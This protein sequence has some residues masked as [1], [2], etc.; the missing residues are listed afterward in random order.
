MPTIGEKFTFTL[1]D[2][3]TFT[4]IRHREGFF[5]IYKDGKKVWTLSARDAAILIS[6][7]GG[8]E[9]E[10][11]PVEIARNSVNGA[12]QEEGQKRGIEQFHADSPVALS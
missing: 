7:L 1:E 5:D 8:H 12:C 4:V 9:P 11:I 6:I 10:P 3:T 2:S